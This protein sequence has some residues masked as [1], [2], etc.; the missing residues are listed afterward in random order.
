MQRI[1]IFLYLLFACIFTMNPLTA[2]APKDTEEAKSD[3][4]IL[5]LLPNFLCPLAVDPDIPADFIALSP[6]ETLDPY[7]WIYWGPK[8]VLKAY[9][10]NPTSLKVPILRVKLSPN[11]AQTG[12]NSFNNQLSLKML[13]KEDPKGFVSIETQWGDYPILAIRTQREDQLIFMAWVGLND[14]GAGWSLMFNL[15][16]PEKKGHPNKEDRQLWESLIMKTTQLKDGDY[17]KACGQDLQ[18]GYT[19]V[20]VGGAKLKM[21]AE[22]R[23]SDGTLQVVIIPEA[24][25]VEFHY[26]DMM[27]CLMGAKW[28]YGEPIVKV[29]G[30]IAVNNENVK[31]TTDYVTSIF[32][33][34]VPEFSFK[35][36]DGKK[37]LIFQKICDKTD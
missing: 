36:G 13:E 18:E 30:E 7:D 27:E 20:N 1:F 10:E 2:I 12:P 19:L 29:Y 22:K 4:R 3:L 21:L 26:V 28:K 9:F 5:E 25:D 32:F 24:S 11:V 31:S 23:Q 35:K 14:P 15:V 6:R 17:F 37:L 33:K 8:D 16:Y 34:T